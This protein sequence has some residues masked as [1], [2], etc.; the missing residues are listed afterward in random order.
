MRHANSA[1]LNNVKVTELIPE[2]LIYSHFV[3]Y[4]NIW[5][6]LSLHTL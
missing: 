5:I 3:D 2:G 6:A 1:N 4:L